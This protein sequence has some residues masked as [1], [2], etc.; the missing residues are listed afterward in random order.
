MRRR[1]PHLSLRILLNLRKKRSIGGNVLPFLG[2][3]QQSTESKNIPYHEPTTGWQLDNLFYFLLPTFLEAVETSW[4]AFYQLSV[5]SMPKDR[6]HCATAAKRWAMQ[7]VQNEMMFW[8]EPW[9]DFFQSNFFVQNICPAQNQSLSVFPMF[10][11]W[12]QLQNLSLFLSPTE[13]R[14]R[15]FYEIC[16]SLV[17]N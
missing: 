5:F 15:V 8:T 16:D 17:P 6:K 12:L 11:Y 13:H 9:I 4:M 14:Y 2:I 3:N 1:S 7:K 10:N